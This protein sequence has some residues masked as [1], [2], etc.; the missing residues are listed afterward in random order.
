MDNG[1]EHGNHYSIFVL[2]G[3]NGKKNGSY[4][5]CGCTPVTLTLPLRTKLQQ[6]EEE[7]EDL[8]PQASVKGLRQ[9]EHFNFFF[10]I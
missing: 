7:N 5:S 2:Y 1:N 6:V 9:L 4:Y 3:D 8:E 10:A